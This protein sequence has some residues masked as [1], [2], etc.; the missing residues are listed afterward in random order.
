MTLFSLWTRLKQELSYRWAASWHH[1]RFGIRF[2]DGKVQRVYGK[3]NPRFLRALKDFRDLEELSEGWM[4]AV[5]SRQ[6][7]R[8]L[9]IIG[10]PHFSEV[11]LQRLRNLL[12]SS[13]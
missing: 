1:P 2:A 13:V 8:S 3:V 9:K 11:T 10:S 5:P 7:A 6:D 4:M 12:Q